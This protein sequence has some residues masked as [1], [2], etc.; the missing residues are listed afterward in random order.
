MTTLP[1]ILR[2]RYLLKV[3]LGVG[4]E[5]E[6]DDEEGGVEHE[7]GAGYEHCAGARTQLE[8]RHVHKLTKYSSSKFCYT[9]KIFFFP[10]TFLNIF[11]KLVF[12]VNTRGAVQRYS[13]RDL[14]APL[15]LT[16]NTN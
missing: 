13:R 14:T 11:A 10:A 5:D 1:D 8:T 15:L 9:M 16:K 6:V 12:L 4:E 7:V 2:M 3:G